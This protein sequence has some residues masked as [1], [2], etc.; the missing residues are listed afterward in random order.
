M[1]TAEIKLDLH[2]KIDSAGSK[3]SKEIYG[4]VL[5]YLNSNYAIEEWDTLTEAQR[6]SINEGLAQAEA[7]LG[8]PA[9][10]VI[11]KIRKKHGLIESKDLWQDISFE[12]KQ[13]IE[14]GLKQADNG[15]VIPHQE[16]MVKYQKWRSN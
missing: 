3:Q 16:V 13:E 14:E 6:A 5:N 7:G 1:K 4:L 10:E 12:E 11:R 15:E 8:T 2:N 9:S